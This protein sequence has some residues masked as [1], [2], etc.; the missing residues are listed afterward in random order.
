[1]PQNTIWRSNGGVRAGEHPERDQTAETV[2]QGL[3]VE[4]REWSAFQEPGMRS[5]RKLC[6]RDRKIRPKGVCQ[7]PRYR[8]QTAL[9]KKENQIFLI[10]K[11]IQ[12]GAVAKLYMR[13][14][15][16]IYEE[17]KKNV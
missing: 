13:K 2:C 8:S 12:S 10:Y 5:N 11:E 15:F 16:L 3:G 4:I 1:M 6:S 9:I 14:G 17:M 7:G